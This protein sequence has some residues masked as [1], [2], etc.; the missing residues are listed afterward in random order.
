MKQSKI[1][2]CI[3]F[4]YD[5]GNLSSVTS[6]YK[7][8]F[9]D[10]F[11]V[12]EITSLGDTP[13]GH[14]ELCYAQLF[15]QS[16]TLMNTANLHHSFND[17]ISFIITCENQEEID[18]YWDYLTKEGVEYECGWCMDKFGLRF[19]IIPKNFDTLL[20][21]PNSWQVIMKQKKIIIDEYG[22]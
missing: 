20:N 12:S 15:E 22:D 1:T 10:N 8:I 19:Q 5:K 21:K 18:K 14:A 17:S 11:I 4:S 6:Y 7:N 2:P 13:S 16:L 9:E 3:W